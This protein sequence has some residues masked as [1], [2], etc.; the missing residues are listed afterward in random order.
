MHPASPSGRISDVEVTTIMEN[1]V[2]GLKN[3]VYEEWTEDKIVHCRCLEKGAVE[4]S[5]YRELLTDLIEL[6]P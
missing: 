5:E 4:F 6:W 2:H 3:A 1:V